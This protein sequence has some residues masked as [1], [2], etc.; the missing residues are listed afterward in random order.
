MKE[1][2][3]VSARAQQLADDLSELSALVGCMRTAL[4]MTDNNK[5]QKLDVW[6]I[7]IHLDK[8]LIRL[9]DNSCELATTMRGE[10]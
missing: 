6:G 3:S 2:T 5:A 1:L 9:K 4:E 8:A 10:S 7:T